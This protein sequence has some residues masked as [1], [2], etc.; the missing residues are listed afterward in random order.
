MA[1]VGMSGPG[2]AH[3]RFVLEPGW[4]TYAP[5]PGPVGVEPVFTALAVDNVASWD[6]VWPPS[7]VLSSYGGTFHGYDG[8]VDV[9]VVI[10]PLDPLQSARLDLGVFAASC[11][12]LCVPLEA[13]VALVL[14]PVGGVE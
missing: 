5:N 14:G 4:K 1:V 6:V 12:Q 7:K 8:S 2:H 10:R 9:A 3:V 13:E 11:A